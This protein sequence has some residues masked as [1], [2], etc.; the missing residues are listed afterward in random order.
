MNIFG[1]LR[2]RSNISNAASEGLPQIRSSK[3]QTKLSVS[4]LLLPASPPHPVPFPAG[5][6]GSSCSPAPTP[7]INL[8]THLEMRLTAPSAVRGG[9]NS[10][11]N[12]LSPESILRLIF[13]RSLSCRSG[14]RL[15]VEHLELSLELSLPLLLPSDRGLGLPLPL[16]SFTM[17]GF[18]L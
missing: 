8:P 11:E 2:V 5:L 18:L 16:A 7:V 14:S 9:K 15:G 1:S 10:R 13:S 12:H 6:K 3:S 4:P 17:A